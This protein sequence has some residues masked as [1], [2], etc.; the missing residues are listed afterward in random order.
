MCDADDSGLCIVTFGAN[1]LDRMVINF[2]LPDEDY[3]VF[4]IK[5]SNRGIVNVYS[6]EFVG[7]VLISVNCTGSR[8]PLGEAIDI[9]VYT[10][11]GDVLIARGEFIVSAILLSTSESVTESFESETDTPTLE[12]SPTEIIIP[13][14]TES[15]PIP[16]EDA[17]V[18][19][20][21]IPTETQTTS[22]PGEDAFTPTS[23]PSPEPTSP[24]I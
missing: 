7:D 23:T 16:E 15:T 18:T 1:D 19:E 13:T 12:P 21:F 22:T 2:Q 10:T 5:A 6:C 8:T 3:P 4:Y 14:E 24:A 20:T 11:D 9:E 17:S